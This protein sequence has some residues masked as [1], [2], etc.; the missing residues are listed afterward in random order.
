MKPLPPLIP[1]VLLLLGLVQ[2]PALEE[3]TEIE[4]GKA[5]IAKLIKESVEKINELDVEG[6]AARPPDGLQ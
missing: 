2:L 3:K 5:V 1:F 4:S 6:F